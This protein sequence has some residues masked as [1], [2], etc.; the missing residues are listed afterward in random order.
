LAFAAAALFLIL[1]S[2]FVVELVEAVSFFGL[3]FLAGLALKKRYT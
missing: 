3:A 1:G 2:A